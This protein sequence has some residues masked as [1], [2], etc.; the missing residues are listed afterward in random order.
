MI[1]DEYAG[2]IAEDVL[3][4]LENEYEPGEIVGGLVEA[5][6]QLVEGDVDSHRDLA[7]YFQELYDDALGG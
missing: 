1:N 4:A 3:G 5:I 7:Y 2:V 6:T